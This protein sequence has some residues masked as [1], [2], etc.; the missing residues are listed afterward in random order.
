MQYH[1]LRG[2]HGCRRDSRTTDQIPTDRGG[3]LPLT[4]H[5]LCYNTQTDSIY[6]AMAALQRR[7]EQVANE[8]ATTNA[9]QQASQAQ[10]NNGYPYVP[11]GQDN[12]GYPYTPLSHYGNL[13]TANGWVNAF[14]FARPD[15]TYLCTLG[16][17]QYCGKGHYPYNQPPSYAAPQYGGIPTCY[18]DSTG[19]TVCAY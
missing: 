12:N 16:Y 7:D 11:P 17:T 9:D 13:P 5:Q 18:Y 2:A 15:I 8:A 3:K 1:Q 14:R 4:A 10:D 19:N 6:Q